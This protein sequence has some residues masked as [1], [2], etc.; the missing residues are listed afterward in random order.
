MVLSTLSPAQ[1]ALRGK[2]DIIVVHGDWLFLN[3]Q[4]TSIIRVAFSHYSWHCKM[5]QYPP[6]LPQGIHA[7]NFLVRRLKHRYE[8]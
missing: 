4:H 1:V 8:S 2:R 3:S 5:G 6:S 7:A